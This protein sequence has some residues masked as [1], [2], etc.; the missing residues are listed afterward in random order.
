VSAERDLLAEYKTL[1]RAYVR[2]LEAGHDR[3]KS[4]GGECD[5]VQKMEENDPDLQI[6]RGVIASSP[7]VI[8]PAT[9]DQR[10]AA[11]DERADQV[12]IISGKHW[13]VAN[14][15]HDNVYQTIDPAYPADDTLV[16]KTG[17]SFNSDPA[18]SSNSGLADEG[19][20]GKAVCIEECVAPCDACGDLAFF[21]ATNLAQSLFLE[22][23]YY[24]DSYG[25]HGSDFEVCSCCGAE[26][27]AG[28]LRHPFI[29]ADD[30]HVD[31]LERELQKMISAYN[32]PTDEA[33]RKDA[34]RYRWLREHHKYGSKPELTISE[35]RHRSLDPWSGDNPDRAIDAALDASGREK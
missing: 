19:R 7:S 9:P 24:S 2:L 26:N 34:E 13:W 18:N 1:Y 4:L 3:I 22:H 20:E 23:C 15:M 16:N 12:R 29:H 17:E 27:G 5:C 14:H 31:R 28:V 33:M 21:N 11:A 6:A 10:Q 35:I 30:C 25:V 32:D 8:T